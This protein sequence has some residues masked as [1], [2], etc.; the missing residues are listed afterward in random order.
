MS[1]W[2]EMGKKVVRGSACREEDCGLSSVLFL[3]MVVRASA[4]RRRKSCEKVAL[5]GGGGGGGDKK[6]SKAG[7]DRTGF[8]GYAWW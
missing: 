4:A 1:V 6:A 5:G 3:Y 2:A 7:G 8:L